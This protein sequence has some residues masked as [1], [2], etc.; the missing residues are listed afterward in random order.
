MD[1]KKTSQAKP[2]RILK[3]PNQRSTKSKPSSASVLKWRSLWYSSIFQP[4]TNGSISVS[5][6]SSRVCKIRQLKKTFIQWCLQR[7][8]KRNVGKWWRKCGVYKEVLWTR[9][10]YLGTY[11]PDKLVEDGPTDNS[12]DKDEED[13]EMKMK[14]TKKTM[15]KTNMK[16]K[17]M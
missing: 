5:Q 17:K 10:R 4:I 6:V 12:I 1:K 16:M 3:K 9:G 7:G 15:K 8:S 11:D 2:R 14:M 13:T